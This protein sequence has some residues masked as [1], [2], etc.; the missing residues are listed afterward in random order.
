[1]S[2]IARLVWT[3]FTANPLSRTLAALGLALMLAGMSGYLHYP[4]WTLGS[5]MRSSPLW[6]QSLILTAPWFGLILLF[7][8]TST[9][10]AVV[11]RFVLGRTVYVLA[12]GRLCVLLSVLATASAIALLTAATG[13][14]SFLYY[15]DG[16]KPERIF[17]RAWLVAFS[18]IGLMYAALWIVGKT[19]GIWLLVGSLLIVV[20]IVTPLAAIGRP[21]GV[22]PLT[23]AGLAVWAAFAIVVLFGARLRQAASGPAT[24]FARRARGLRLPSLSYSPG[25]ELDLLLGTTRPWVVAIGQA[26]P[27]AFAGWLIPDPR[28]WLFFLTLFTAISGAIT[29]SAAARSRVL[30]LKLGWTRAQMF[31]GVEAA[32]W[33]YNAYPLGVLLMLF[34]GLGS[35]RE[36]STPVLALGVP[37]LVLG[38]IVSANLGLMMTRG[39]GWL[40]TALGIGTMGLLLATAVAAADADSNM[41]LAIELEVLLAALA[42]AYRWSAKARWLRLDWL[43]CRSAATTRDAG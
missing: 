18:N 31:A 32:Y 39:L 16:I 5:G 20:G 13:V 1:M 29:S 6:Y 11:E 26:A 40:E 35:Y 34:V 9:L 27:V 21:S 37:L 33:R 3:Y 43:V 25:A 14:L 15:P 30:W 17:S 22:P 2:P 10:P 42:L 36:L 8:A 12:G 38:G 24:R 28:A 23:V 7:F 4:A 19:R 41:A